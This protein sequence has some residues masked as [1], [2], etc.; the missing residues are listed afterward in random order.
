LE[1]GKSIQL[2]LFTVDGDASDKGLNDWILDEDL[3]ELLGSF[4]LVAYELNFRE[5][6]FATGEKER[7]GNQGTLS[8]RMRVI[9]VL[10]IA[11]CGNNIVD[12]VLRD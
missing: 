11:N 4:R 9:R 2:A 12:N 10:D 6:L 7:G 1:N 3:M 8:D 5:Q